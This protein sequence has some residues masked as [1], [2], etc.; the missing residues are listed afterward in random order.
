MAYNVS[1][2]FPSPF[3]E[4]GVGTSK[5]E[6]I[7]EAEVRGDLKVEELHCLKFWKGYR[8]RDAVEKHANT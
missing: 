3:R 8:I 1:E 7:R 4:K 2:Y 6:G 5:F